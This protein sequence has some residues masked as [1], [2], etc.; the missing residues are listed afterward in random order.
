MT[1][2]Q[3]QV[4]YISGFDPRGAGHYHRLYKSQAA[5]Q[6]GANGLDI[7]VSRRIRLSSHLHQWRLD[8]RDTHS[9]YNF[10]SWDDII[11][12]NWAR[13]WPAIVTDF[14]YCLWVYIATGRIL[15][16]ARASRK[17]ML[18]GLYPVFFILLA[19]ATSGYLGYLTFVLFPLPV[20]PGWLDSGLRCLVAMLFLWA[21]MAGFKHLGNK[22]AVFWLLRIYAFSA[23]WANGDIPGLDQR[24]S[25]FSD[26]IIRAIEDTDNQEVVIIAHSVGTMLAVPVM[27]LVLTHIQDKPLFKDHRVILIT[28]GHCIPLL[29]FQPRATPFRHALQRLAQD[30]RLLWLDYSA[31]TD[32]ACFPLLDPV[33]SC[34]LIRTREAGPRILSPRF[35]TL[36]HAAHYKRLSRAWYAMHFLY[37]MAT[38]KAGPYDFFAFTAGPERIAARLEQLQ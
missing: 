12:A 34:G 13:G 35:F 32:G 23:K 28:L 14:C 5:K 4:F 31:P 25:V 30:P 6:A 22:L 9:R 15:V 26:E 33:T 7:E 29:S 18:A 10:L 11:R 36:Y 21:A 1:I 3:R 20:L 8:T 27:S 19:L 37:L 16:F 17:Q 2:K 38:D 24:I